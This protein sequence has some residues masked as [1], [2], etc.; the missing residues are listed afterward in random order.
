MHFLVEVGKERLDEIP[1]VI[2][3]VA[4]LLR[5]G[6]QHVDHLLAGGGGSGRVNVADVALERLVVEGLPAIHRNA[7]IRDHFVVDDDGVHID[8]DG[9]VHVRLAA[10]GGQAL[11]GKRG[12]VGLQIIDQPCVDA[13]A[14]A[15]EHIALRV[16]GLRLDAGGELA[17]AVHDELELAIGILLR[18]D[19]RKDLGKVFA[20]GAVDHQRAGGDIRLRFAVIRRLLRLRRIGPGGGRLGGVGRFCRLLRAARHAEHERQNKADKCKYLS[21]HNGSSLTVFFRIMPG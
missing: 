18:P 19:P 11:R 3:R 7:E 17:A 14:A 20:A 4:V 15:D 6:G 10:V 2:H 13:V 5:H 16:I 1:V 12:Y 21:V 9:G 8:L